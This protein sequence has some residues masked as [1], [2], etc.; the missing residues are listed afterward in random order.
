MK[1]AMHTIAKE[2][3]F[4]Y[5]HRVHNQILNQ[6]Y[7]LDNACVCRHLHGHQGRVLVYLSEDHLTNGMVTDFKHLNWFKKFLDDT[8]D[9]KFIMDIN[10]P[11]LEHEVLRPITAESTALI[12]SFRETG[13]EYNMA[14]PYWTIKP[15]WYAGF[16]PHVRE[17]Y[18]GMV[19]V[20]FVPTS[21]NL[22]KWLYHIVDNKMAGFGIKISRVQFFETPKSQANY[23]A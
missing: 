2:F 8:L 16:E 21:E 7:S 13:F 14:G 12:Q 17:K 6:Q 3:E 1:K 19:F 23:Y 18:E 22:S 4:C 5:G 20:N 10:D 9:H 15:E 11:L